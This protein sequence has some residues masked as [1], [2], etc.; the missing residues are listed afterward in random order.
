MGLWTRVN[1]I[2][3]ARKGDSGTRSNPVRMLL[4]QI[5]D[6]FKTTFRTIQTIEI[7]ETQFNPIGV[8]AMEKTWRMGNWEK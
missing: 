3:N 8:Q 1:E 4:N 2:M 5:R 7:N 6:T